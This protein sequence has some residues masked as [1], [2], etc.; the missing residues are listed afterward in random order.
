MSFP[1]MGLPKGMHPLETETIR[2]L[3]TLGYNLGPH[4]CTLPTEE[5]LTEDEGEDDE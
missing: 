2:R 5:E 4:A 3:D 1:G